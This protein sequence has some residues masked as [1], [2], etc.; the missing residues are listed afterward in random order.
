MI[1]NNVF[2]QTGIKSPV[3]R[4]A[5]RFYHFEK[6]YRTALLSFVYWWPS[7]QGGACMISTITKFYVATYPYF[8]SL[9][10]YLSV[11]FIFWKKYTQH[12]KGLRWLG[13]STLSGLLLSLGF[14]PSP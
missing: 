3:W 13:L 12:P 5:I 2:R 10:I 14:P 11:V 1:F 8:S 6:Q 7:A 9:S 4:K